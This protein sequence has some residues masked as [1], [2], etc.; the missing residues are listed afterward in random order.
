MLQTTLRVV[1]RGGGRQCLSV[2]S[3]RQQW[4]TSLRSR[5]RWSTRSRSAAASTAR[6]SSTTFEEQRRVG[7]LMT[8]YYV[9]LER[10]EEKAKGAKLGW[11]LD[12]E[13]TNGRVSRVLVV[14]LSR[15][16]D[17]GRGVSLSLPPSL[18][19]DPEHRQHTTVG[20]DW[21]ARGFSHRGGDGRVVH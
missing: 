11:T 7:K 8:Q 2:P 12:N 4:K 6:V 10:D 5:T 20:H 13:I 14:G 15:P 21:L 17:R 3:P 19:T 18:I 9:D 1:N 16:T